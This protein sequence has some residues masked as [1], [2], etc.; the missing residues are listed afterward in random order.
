L[1]ASIQAHYQTL[2]RHGIAL[3]KTEDETRASTILSPNLRLL[4]SPSRSDVA[5]SE[6]VQPQQPTTH[7]HHG[8]L[9]PVMV[10]QP[11]D[12]SAAESL[13]SKPN[14]NSHFTISDYASESSAPQIPFGSPTQHPHTLQTQEQPPLAAPSVYQQNLQREASYSYSIDT[15]RNPGEESKPNDHSSQ[16]S[17]AFCLFVW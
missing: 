2:E 5:P 14:N 1:E 10:N 4:D 7:H 6:R 15:R 13:T 12:R 17:Y 8:M 3:K 9:P 16:A 11:Q